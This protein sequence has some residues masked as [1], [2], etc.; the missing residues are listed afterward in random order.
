MVLQVHCCR[1]VSERHIAVDAG[2]PAAARGVPCRGQRRLAAA[3]RERDLLP[4]PAAGRAAQIRQVRL[5]LSTDMQGPCRDCK[6]QH[7]LVAFVLWRQAPLCLRT[8]QPPCH[9]HV[10]SFAC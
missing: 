4:S 6:A 3:S 7:S 2:G 1:A 8:V 5:D 9:A 10:L